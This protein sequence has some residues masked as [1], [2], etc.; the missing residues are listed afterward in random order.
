MQQIRFYK[1]TPAED[2]NQGI[3]FISNN[4]VKRDSQ[5]RV[6]P[7]QRQAKM[8]NTPFPERAT[9]KIIPLHFLM[10]K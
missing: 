1:Y 6:H 2:G 3:F 8:V 9:R 5:S 10:I 7:L 4:T